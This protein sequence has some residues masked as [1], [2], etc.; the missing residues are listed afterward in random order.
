MARAAD[1][2]LEVAVSAT[3]ANSRDIRK[4]PE[5]PLMRRIRGTEMNAP[6]SPVTVRRA[7]PAGISGSV[8]SAGIGSALRAAAVVA[9]AAF[10]CA[11]CE[12]PPAGPPPHE[13]AALAREVERLEAARAADLPVAVEI[14]AAKIIER[15]PA[16]QEAAA[17][18]TQLPS[19]RAAAEH[20]RDERRRA[21]LWRYSAA[22]HAEGFQLM[23]ELSSDPVVDAPPL[24]LVLRRHPRFGPAA[25]LLIDGGADF[26]CPGTCT[27]Q[28]LFDE[29]PSRGFAMRRAPDNVP[30]AL[31]LRDHE[32][33]MTAL[34]AA[35]ELRVEVPLASGARAT[36]RFDVGGYEPDRMQGDGTQARPAR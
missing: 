28:M 20:W 13:R 29:G 9:L 36:Y 24:R 27:L 30:P 7:A 6:T 10:L 8:G 33:F 19:L 16:S 31:F 25:Y 4:P 18:R 3:I 15:F 14:Y 32:A 1:A 12:R 26:A 2:F 17:L 22:E 35:G 5:L 23:A 34:E 11:G 21:D